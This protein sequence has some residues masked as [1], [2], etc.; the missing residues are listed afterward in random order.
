MSFD[1]KLRYV[2]GRTPAARP[3]A[4]LLAV[5]AA[6]SE[7]LPI[8]RRLKFRRLAA[9]WAEHTAIDQGL[10][11]TIEDEAT[12]REIARL[13]CDVRNDVRVTGVAR[14]Q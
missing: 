2:Y 3:S 4:R 13:L 8:T 12:L 9:E 5:V 11:P 10:P 1:Q 14:R 6:D 7:V